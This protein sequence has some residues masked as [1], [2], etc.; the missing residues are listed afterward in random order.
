MLAQAELALGE[1]AVFELAS[2]TRTYAVP[3]E[4]TASA[5]AGAA[6]AGSS[7]LYVGAE[8]GVLGQAVSS[9]TGGAFAAANYAAAGLAVSSLDSQ[10]VLPRRMEGAGRS[11]AALRGSVFVQAD[12]YSQSLADVLL[13]SGV[14]LP[15]AFSAAGTSSAVI[16]YLNE[17]EFRIEGASAASFVGAAQ[18]NVDMNAAG[19][20]ELQP[21]TR[22]YANASAVLSGQA[23]AA[24]S[25]Q[26]HVLSSAHAASAASS[27]LDGQAVLLAAYQSNGATSA[28]I[29]AQTLA[30]GSFIGHGAAIL[31]FDPAWIL[32]QYGLFAGV[33]GGSV[34]LDAGSKRFVAGRLIAPGAAQMSVAGALVTQAALSSQGL[35]SAVWR[36]G[37]AVMAH[38][39]PA[40]DVAIRPEDIVAAVRPDEIRSVEKN[41]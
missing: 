12:M 38:L 19:L 10:I 27:G 9:W 3:A 26:A 29:T 16:Y 1:I 28:A 5:A 18:V 37:H 6:W 35:S 33:G 7:A 17:P 2:E 30:Y 11:A 40:F 21:Q 14:G 15:G 23:S 20:A 39:D 36:K 4:F 25:G 32:R 24:L 22:S 41:Q 13:E 8:L 34:S 31:G